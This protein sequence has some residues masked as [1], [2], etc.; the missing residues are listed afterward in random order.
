[1]SVTAILVDGAFYRRKFEK[2][3][4]HS[5]SEAADALIRYCSRHLHEH[6]SKHSLY[7]IF[8]Y[9]C[10]PSTK[11]IFHPLHNRTFD[12]SKSE[13]HKW[14]S[15][16]LKEL[17]QKRKV[18][19]RLGYLDDANASYTLKQESAKMLVR[20]QKTLDA[21]DDTDFQPTFKQKGVDMRIGMDIASLSYKHQVT[22][23]VLIAGDAD[24]V[25]ASKL[26]RSQRGNRF[27]S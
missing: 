9:D 11:K 21:L 23:I 13:H 20:K 8:Y 16:F 12:L 6:G 24:F 27:C 15:A 1:M 17:T 10:K 22:Q 4:C 5:P 19:V 26:A 14:M 2:N 18:A 25:P 3:C 7:R